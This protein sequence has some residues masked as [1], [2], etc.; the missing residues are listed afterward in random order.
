MSFS[1]NVGLGGK[2][3]PQVVAMV[4]DRDL[5]TLGET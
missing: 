5:R 1:V 3:S 4:G 2:V